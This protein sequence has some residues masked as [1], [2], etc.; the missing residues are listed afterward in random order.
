MGKVKRILRFNVLTGTHR[1]YQFPMG[2]VKTQKQKIFKI[3]AQLYQFPMG[4]V[5]TNTVATDDNSATT[6]QFPMGKVK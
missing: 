5:K 2:K 6:Y 1:Q 4:K 3:N